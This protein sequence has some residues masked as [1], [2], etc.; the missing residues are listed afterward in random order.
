[1][2]EPPKRPSGAIPGPPVPAPPPGDRA[3]LPSRLRGDAR[4][5]RD[6]TQTSVVTEHRPTLTEFGGQ[7]RRKSATHRHQQTVAYDAATLDDPSADTLPGVGLDELVARGP[8]DADD[9]VA[10]IRALAKLLEDRHNRGMGHGGLTPRHIRYL[11]D[12]NGDLVL[13]EVADVKV[14]E[15]YEAHYEAPELSGALQTRTVTP[16]RADVYALGAIFFEMLCGQPPF[17]ANTP[18]E[19]RQ[20][21]A[22]AAAPGARQVNPDT[23]VPPAV[24][25]VVQRALKKRPGDRYPDSTTFGADLNTANADDDRGTVHLSVEEAGYLKEILEAKTQSER[26]K[27]EIEEEKRRLEEETRQA[28]AE[29]ARAEARTLEAEAARRRSELAEAA[30]EKRK[31]R[32]RV[33]IATAVVAVVVAGGAAAWFL[34]RDPEVVTKTETVTKTVTKTEVKTEVKVV[35]VPVFIEAGPTEP[36]DAGAAEPVEKPVAR[37]PRPRPKP[38]QAPSPPK[39]DKPKTDPNLPAIF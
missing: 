12:E 23:D 34:T 2:S 30:A 16:T 39:P 36:P 9:A 25:R 20:K 37:R 27:A 29:R 19:L 7:Q 28:E 21:H 13:L 8:L 11:P 32:L 38:E 17:E 31:R 26:T 22:R 5:E 4:R 10:H 3:A 24:E 35:E 14:S 1:V 15:L 18:A 33:L 6:Q